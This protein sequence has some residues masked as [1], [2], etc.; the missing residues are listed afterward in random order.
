MAYKYKSSLG[1]KKNKVNC[2]GEVILAQGQA[3]DLISD[4]GKRRIWRSRIDN[5][6]SEEKLV[7]GRWEMVD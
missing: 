6:I 4:S 1:Q 5:S 2:Y 3:D 7:N